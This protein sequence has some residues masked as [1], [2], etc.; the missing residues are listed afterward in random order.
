MAAA[1]KFF[2][3]ITFTGSAFEG[4]FSIYSAQNFGAGNMPR[5]RQGFRCSV[6]LSLAGA[7]VIAVVAAVFGKEMIGI[8]ITGEPKELQQIIQVGYEYLVILA[9][10]VPL[11]FLLCL[12]RAGLQG[13]GS[14]LVPTLSGFVELGIRILS[15]SVL[16]G[17]LNKW[18]VYSATPLG[19]LAAVILLGASYHQMYRRYTG[20]QGHSEH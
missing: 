4:A 3:L 6:L 8:L 11:M 19:W 13:M 17:I 15:V 20:K 16:P 14:T 5:F 9:F 7:F 2:E 1:E 10:T 18:A 12:Y